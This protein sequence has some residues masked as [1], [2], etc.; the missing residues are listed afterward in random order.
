MLNTKY[1]RISEDFMEVEKDGVAQ[2]IEYDYIVIAVASKSKNY[3]EIKTYCEC[4]NFAKYTFTNNADLKKSVVCKG[5]FLRKN[6][7]KVTYFYL[8]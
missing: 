7:C 4:N 8:R 6:V 5:Y 3:D 2:N 1:T